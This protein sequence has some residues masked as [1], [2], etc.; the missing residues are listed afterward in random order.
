MTLLGPLFQPRAS[1]ENPAVPLTSTTL[2][3]WLGI[4]SSPSGVHVSQESALTFPAVYRAINLIAGTAASLPLH[5]YKEGDDSKLPVGPDSQA[6]KLL[7]QPHPDLEPFDFWELVYG[8]RLAW[9]NAYCWKLRNRAGRL[10]ELWPIHPSRVKAGRVTVTGAMGD[11]KDVGRK[12]YAIDGGEGAGGVTAYDD[13]ILHLPAFG[14]DGI[15]GFSPIALARNGVGLG[16]A[17]EEFGGKLFGSGSL[18]AGILETDQKLT[19]E[20]ADRL[21]ARWKAKAAGLHNSHEAVILDYGTKF[22]QLTIPPEDAQFLE[23]RKFQVVEIARMFGVPPHMLMEVSGST[24]WGTG[25][26]QQTLGFVVFCLRPWL[27]RTEQRITR[28]LKP[29]NVYAKY[30]L[31]GLLRGASKERAEFY[32]KMFQLGA[33]STNDIR[34]YEDLSPVANGD[35]RYR[36]LNLGPLG[37]EKAPEPLPPAP[38]QLPPAPEPD[39]EPEE[40]TTDA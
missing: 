3:D 9:G 15:T 6:A 28:I 8:H 16:L 12:I 32:T 20:Q 11:S 24:S 29:E 13:Q 33:L 17:A 14:Y 25:I 26:E 18:A 21:H 38:P 39:T 34:A 27:V 7:A 40:V 36:P 35:E 2:L 23:T 5:A 30:S 4:K 37:E 1:V 19:E 10:A 31:E 22:H